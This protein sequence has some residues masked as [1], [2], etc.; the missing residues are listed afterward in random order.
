M[1]R[2]RIAGRHG[3]R[4]AVVGSAEIGEKSAENKGYTTT[5]LQLLRRRVPQGGP[6][7]QF[8]DFRYAIR[9]RE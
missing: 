7:E 3:Y 1:K 5:R 9:Y 6:M 4:V 2:N 8:S